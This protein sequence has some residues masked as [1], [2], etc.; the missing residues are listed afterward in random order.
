MDFG[1]LLYGLAMYLFGY[2]WRA[3]VDHRAVKRIMAQ[4][5]PAKR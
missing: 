3:F 5:P 1:L 2:G 4:R